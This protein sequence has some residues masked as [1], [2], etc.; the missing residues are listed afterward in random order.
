VTKPMAEQ[1]TR[2]YCLPC[3]RKNPSL[4]VTYKET[5]DEKGVHILWSDCWVLRH[6]WEQLQHGP[7][8]RRL[9]GDECE[10]AGGIYRTNKCICT[11]P[12]ECS[13]YSIQCQECSRWCHYECEGFTFKTGKEIS[14]YYCHHCRYYYDLSIEYR[15]RWKKP[16][17]SGRCRQARQ[18][19]FNA[20]QQTRLNIQKQTEQPMNES[21]SLTWSI[22]V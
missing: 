6:K 19:H 2:F 20:L 8:R 14:A 21:T 1:M 12:N 9:P 10:F 7:Q 5:P 15:A 13:P 18:A 4:H 17:S 3:R 22:L 11:V 16:H